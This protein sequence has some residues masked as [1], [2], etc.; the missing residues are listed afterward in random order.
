MIR[1]FRRTLDAS[2]T[3]RY[4]NLPNNS[5]LELIEASTRRVAANV[6][7]NLVTES[8]DRLQNDFPSSSK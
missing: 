3:V 1:H 5:Q 4:A 6:T 8:G 7:V 2:N